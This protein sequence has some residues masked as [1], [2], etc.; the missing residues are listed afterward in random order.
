MTW[1]ALWEAGRGGKRA[2]G[3]PPAATGRGTT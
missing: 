2:A 1:G 3:Q